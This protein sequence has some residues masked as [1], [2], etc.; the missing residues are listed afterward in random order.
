[1]VQNYVVCRKKPDVNI[2]SIKYRLCRSVI[3]TVMEFYSKT[4][5]PFTSPGWLLAGTSHNKGAQWLVVKD[6]VNSNNGQV[7]PEL[8]LLTFP[9]SQRADSEFNR[10]N[11]HRAHVH[12]GFSVAR[13]LRVLDYNRKPTSAFK[14]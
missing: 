10:F 7:T 9:S 6:L 4:I 3:R 2:Q 1:M 11:V 8:A 12:G 14:C 13:R 5:V